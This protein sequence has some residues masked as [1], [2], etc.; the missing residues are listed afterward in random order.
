M[1]NYLNALDGERYCRLLG[2]GVLL[3]F[4]ELTNYLVADYTQKSDAQELEGVQAV[5]QRPICTYGTH[6]SNERSPTFLRSP[7]T[8]L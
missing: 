6:C 1:A 5:F 4:P 3:H 7:A 8:A 2:V